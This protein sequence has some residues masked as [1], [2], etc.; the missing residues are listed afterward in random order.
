MKHFR[1]RYPLPQIP[2]KMCLSVLFCFQRANEPVWS[3][4]M[5]FASSRAFPHRQSEVQCDRRF[6]MY[7]LTAGA[8]FCLVN[9]W[10]KK[11]SV[12]NSRSAFELSS[13]CWVAS[14]LCTTCWTIIKNNYY[15]RFWTKSFGVRCHR[16]EPRDRL[17]GSGFTDFSII[18]HFSKTGICFY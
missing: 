14:F 3:P 9:S 5:R 8:R 4:K 10:R 16:G 15:S 13:C 1:L 17:V 11:H 6:G 2:L 12:F 18:G 7:A